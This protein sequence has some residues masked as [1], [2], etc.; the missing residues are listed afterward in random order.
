MESP[1]V[2]AY[3]DPRVWE[4]QIGLLKGFDVFI[5]A[6]MLDYREHMYLVSGVLTL[7]SPFLFGWGGVEG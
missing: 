6:F 3:H 4:Q 7:N 1:S 5:S 2:D